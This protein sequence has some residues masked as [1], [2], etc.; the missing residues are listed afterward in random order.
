MTTIE[1]ENLPPVVQALIYTAV[2]FAAAVVGAFIMTAWN[3]GM[4][5]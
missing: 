3:L 5:P 2:L 1:I 4:I